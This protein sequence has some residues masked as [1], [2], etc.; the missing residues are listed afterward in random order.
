MPCSTACSDWCCYF[1][2]EV[3]W[4]RD[5]CGK[6]VNEPC[7]ATLSVFVRCMG[8]MPSLLLS[9][10]GRVDWPPSNETLYLSRVSSNMSSS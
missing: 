2:G 3:V 8:E 7:S 9:P 4:C 10:S 1:V 6:V 5:F